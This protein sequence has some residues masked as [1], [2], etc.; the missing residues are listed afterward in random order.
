ML[1]TVKD[2]R[3]TRAQKQ[4]EQKKLHILEHAQLV[5][6]QKGFQN[7][8][9]NDVLE[10]SGV[11]RGTFYLY[12]K[13]REELFC[14]LVD[15]FVDELKGCIHSIDYE[16]PNPV[17]K[18]YSNLHRVLTLLFSKKDL[19]TILFREAVGQEHMVQVQEKLNGLYT[20]LLRKVSGAL[21]NGAKRG[22]IRKGNE[23]WL[24]IALIGSIKELVYHFLIAKRDSPPP[25]D[26]LLHEM[27]LFS[28]QGLK[29]S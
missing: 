7:T 6:S 15:Q 19:T 8:S 25:V 18:L 12:F 10:A 14:E 9:V 28:F 1:S 13:N 29:K 23:R 2:R 17:D 24:S 5:I 16:D 26:D 4:R 22:F 3:S 11:S 20:F 21:S 27:V